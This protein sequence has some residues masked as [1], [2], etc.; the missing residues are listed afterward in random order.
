MEAIVSMLNSIGNFIASIVDVVL[1]LVQDV[2]YVIQITAKTV[3]SIPT[4]FT[5]LPT[6]AAGLIVT[7]FGVVVVYKV[8]G[9][10]G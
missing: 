4:Y 3:A 9:R 6:A 1:G 7:I 5:W 2:V 8:I 10:E